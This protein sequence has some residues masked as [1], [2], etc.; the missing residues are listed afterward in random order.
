M[1]SCLLNEPKIQP[2]PSYTY[3]QLIIPVHAS[4]RL[5]VMLCLR[6]ISDVRT[7]TLPSCAG[8]IKAVSWTFCRIGGKEAPRR[9]HLITLALSPRCFQWSP[10]SV[11]TTT[12]WHSLNPTRPATKRC[13]NSVNLTSRSKPSRSPLV[14]QAGTIPSPRKC[15]GFK[16]RLSN[17]P[18]LVISDHEWRKKCQG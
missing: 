15:A 8:G 11:V 18:S 1:I 9:S 3:S 5:N 16:C 13:H 14:S 7:R 17:Q 2:S 6:V 12:R 10:G 4:A